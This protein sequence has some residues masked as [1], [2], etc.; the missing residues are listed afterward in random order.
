MNPETYKT[1]LTVIIT[2]VV[3]G[4]FLAGMYMFPGTTSVAMR[5]KNILQG[6]DIPSTG[7]YYLDEYHVVNQGLIDSNYTDIRIP[8]I[9]K[10]QLENAIIGGIKEMEDKYDR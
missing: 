7:R 4:L 6:G 1:V 9:R 8:L 2:V 5:L 3:L 10:A